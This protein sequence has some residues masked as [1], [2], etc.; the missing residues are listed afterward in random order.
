[1]SKLTNVSSYNFNKNIII[2]WLSYVPLWTDF[3]LAYSREELM[4]LTDELDKGLQKLSFLPF[5]EKALFTL[6]SEAEIGKVQSLFKDVPP[7]MIITIE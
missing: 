1:M 2:S 3:P 6:T 5:N 4:K 7:G